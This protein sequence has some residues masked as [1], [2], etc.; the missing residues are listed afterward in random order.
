MELLV[1][2]GIQVRMELSALTEHLATP[3]L[4]VPQEPLG[5]QASVVFKEPPDTA[6][7]AV[8]SVVVAIQAS[9]D[10]V[11]QGTPVSV[12]IVDSKAPLATLVKMEPQ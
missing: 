1:T 12:A 4:V 10:L 8:L 7:S 2:L 3:V 5:I 11:L 6:A 9:L